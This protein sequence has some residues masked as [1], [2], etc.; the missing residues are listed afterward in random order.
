MNNNTSLKMTIRQQE[1]VESVRKIICSRGIKNLT[2]HEI[3]KRLE[4]TDGALY[5]HFRSKAEIISQLIDEIEETLLVTIKEA[6]DKSADPIQKLENIFLF[7]LSYSQQRKGITFKIIN[8]TLNIENKSLQRKM[9]GVINKY[10]KTIEA[11]LLEGVKLGKLR[12]D[13]DCASASIVFFGIVQS[14]VTHW[15]LGGFRSPLEKNHLDEML[16]IYKN[17]VLT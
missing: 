5:R 11:I 4:V 3:A 1:I 7:H 14:M 10:L 16:N 15:A 2:I 17:G 12:K 9:F 6:I 13:L 8:E